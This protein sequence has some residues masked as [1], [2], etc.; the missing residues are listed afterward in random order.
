MGAATGVPDRFGELQMHN[1]MVAL[2]A[3]SAGFCA[4][5]IVANLYKILFKKSESAAGKVGNSSN[6]WRI[7]STRFSRSWS[8]AEDIAADY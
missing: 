3:I 5:G 2:L 7:S 4:S 8:G 6:C 1:A